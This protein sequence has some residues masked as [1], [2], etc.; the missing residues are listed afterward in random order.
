MTLVRHPVSKMLT[1]MKNRVESGYNYSALLV[2][3]AIIDFGTIC[4]YMIVG[5]LLFYSH[6][7]L[8]GNRQRLYPW[9]AVAI[10][11]PVSTSVRAI[12]R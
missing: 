6:T 4:T 9:D 12:D 11:I 5:P 2:Y 7:T 1:F 10:Y 8:L 3:E